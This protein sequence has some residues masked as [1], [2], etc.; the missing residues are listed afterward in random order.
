MTVAE[1]ELV[2]KKPAASARATVA[3]ELDLA[4]IAKPIADQF[5]ASL[6]RHTDAYLRYVDEEIAKQK[7]RGFAEPVTPGIPPYPYWNLL[8][9][10]PFQLLG[11][12]A[13]GPFLPHK[14]INATEVA[15]MIGALWRNP[16]GINWIPGPS[17]VTVMSTL[18]MSVQFQTLNM[19]TGVAGPTFVPAGVPSP[20]GFGNPLVFFVPI[21]FP[22]PPQGT[23][24]LYEINLVADVSGPIAGLPYAG[25]SSWLFSPDAEPPFLGRPPMP[26]AWQHDVPARVLVYTA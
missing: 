7:A 18:T 14:I 10:G 21:A 11:G 20:L 16:A 17:A 2:I 3:E 5:A 19:T 1:K 8:M 4:T 15:F 13:V 9:A 23:P 25:Y 24:H 6:N 22:A 12:G 26:P